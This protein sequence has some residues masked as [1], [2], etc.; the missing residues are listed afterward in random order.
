MIKPSQFNTA[1]TPGKSAV[2]TPD[3]FALCLLLAAGLQITDTLLPRIP[4]FPWLRLGLSHIVMVPFLLRFGPLPA[5]ALFLCRNLAASI[6]GAQPVTSFII[7]SLSGAISLSL[8]GGGLRYLYLRGALGLW[9]LST[10]LAACFNVLQLSV[11]NA[12]LIQ[13]S[14]FFF[15]LG[16]I[17]IWS[18]ISGGLV[19]VIVNKAGDELSQL[20]E[21]IKLPSPESGPG[22]PDNTLPFLLGLGIMAF[23]FVSKNLYVYALCLPVLIALTRLK[24]LKLLAMAWP[25]YLY[26]A[27]FYLFEGEG[28][29]LP[30]GI[31][32]REGA[33][34]FIMYA[35]RLACLMLLGVWLADRI[36]VTWLKGRKSLYLQG[37]THAVAVMPE[38][39]NLSMRHGRGFLWALFR[40]RWQGLLKPLLSE[41]KIKLTGCL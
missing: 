19:A 7:S 20:F 23:I 25:F 30:G 22:Q 15:Q 18:V 32:T 33:L 37:F 4:I 39:F 14:G 34:T 3:I 17:I 11:V 5:V 2:L 21:P 26:L 27:W 10:L 6:Y 35:L 29:Y 12:A 36:P 24:G 41:I 9:G 13:H 40:G 1:D 8:C 31:I 38:L 16:P 28:A